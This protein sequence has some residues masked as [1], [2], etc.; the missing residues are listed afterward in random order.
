MPDPRDGSE[1][2]ASA[3]KRK[4]PETLNLG[5]MPTIT[6][7]P[8]P[9]SVAHT[10]RE[11]HTRRADETREEFRERVL[12]RT[13]YPVPGVYTPEQGIGALER[14]SR[15]AEDDPH[16]V[17]AFGTE[18]LSRYRARQLP[19]GS[20]AKRRNRSIVML[21]IRW[22]LRDAWDYFIGRR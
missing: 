21:E 15:E 13:I 17:S 18:P 16:V 11:Y 3:P 12:G 1:E 8:G 19:E 9:D 14:S 4:P 10:F 5:R 20:R 7:V 2:G 6:R 22:L